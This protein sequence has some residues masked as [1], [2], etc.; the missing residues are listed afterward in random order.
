MYEQDLIWQR[1]GGK[2]FKEEEINPDSARMVCEQWNE[3]SWT[4][5]FWG[6]IDKG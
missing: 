6:G 1:R 5:D 3:W 2:V 4:I